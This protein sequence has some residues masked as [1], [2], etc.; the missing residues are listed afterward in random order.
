MRSLFSFARCS[1]VL[2]SKAVH[3][4]P[5]KVDTTMRSSGWAR[6]FRTDSL[7][8]RCVARAACSAGVCLLLLFAR[9]A[10]AQGVRVEGVVHDNSGAAIAGAA[11]TLNAGT[12]TASATTDANGTFTL[13]NFG[14]ARG[15]VTVRAAGFAEVKRAWDAANESSVH[16]EIVLDVASVREQVVVTAT[17]MP[18]P[19]GDVAGSSVALTQEDLNSTPALAIDDKLKQIPG[20]ELFRRTGSRWA[21]PTAQGVSLSGLGASGASRALVLEDG[22]PLNDPFGGWI[23]WPAIPGTGLAR[24]EVVSRGASSLYGGDALGG[25]IQFFERQPAE[26]SLAVDITY[27]NQ[28]T[29]DLSLWTGTKAGKWDVA[30]SADLY[31][32]DGYILVPPEDRGTVDVPANSEDAAV[33]LTIGRQ[34]GEH[35]RVWGRGAYF[36]ESRDNGTPIQTNDTQIGWGVLGLDSQVGTRGTISARLYGDAQSYDQSF[37]SVAANRD[38][39]SLTDLQH[40]PAQRLGGTAWWSQAVG[41]WQTIGVGFELGEVTGASD[42]DIFSSGRQTAFQTAG[43]HQFNFG[44]FGEDVVRIGTR[45]SVTGSLRYDRVEYLDGETSRTAPPTPPNMTTSVLFPDRTETAFSPRLSV[46][47]ALSRNISFSA[48]A[49]HSFRSPTLNELYRSFRQGNVVT[50]A[51]PGLVAERLTGGEAGVSAATLGGRLTIRGNFFWNQI[52]DPIENVTIATT[53]TLIT[54]LRENLGETRSAGFDL[55]GVMQVTR[56]LEISGGYQFVNATVLDFS[57]NPALVG[58]KIPQVPQNQFT[59]QGRY[60]NSGYLLS[61]EGRFTGNQFDDDQNQFPLGKYFV[62]DMMAGR[63]L[64]HGMLL[65]AAFENL[66]NQRYNVALTPTPNIGPQFLVRGGLRYTLP[67]HH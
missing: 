5:R 46:L 34:L 45:W 7:Q 17:R 63:S 57:N 8:P 49:Y 31:H 61:V 41:R 28:N 33:S 52:T 50:G 16:L 60:L 67:E 56:N 32:T 53:P 54:R 35:T 6:S 20:F 4:V 66:L 36:T 15:T 9:A 55:E 13:E 19:L 37:S 23:Q 12:T 30:F 10:A 3:G 42:E 2:D 47:Y 14:E 64:G 1:G 22:V 18:T 24:A 21:N 40:V 59:L 58:L 11:V 48:A 51:N 27:G 26:P 62:V 38:S 43:G 29:P 65:Y 44:I 39:E 25:V